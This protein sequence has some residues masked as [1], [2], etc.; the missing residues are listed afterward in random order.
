MRLGRLLGVLALAACSPPERDAAAFAAEPEA[1]LQVVADCDAGAHRSDCAA[2]R[3]GLAEARRRDRMD[4]YA[5][6]FREP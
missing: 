3:G 1:A 6:T 5:R 2:A 4:A